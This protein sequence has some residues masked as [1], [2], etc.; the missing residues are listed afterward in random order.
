MR[1]LITGVGGFVGR[2]MWD[3]LQK[4][5]RPPEVF[6]LTR[7]RS[8][9][10]DRRIKFCDMTDTRSLSRVL[11]G[12]DPD[13]IFHLAGGR[14]LNQRE[15]WE[16][17]FG[18]TF[19]LLEVVE[20]L[21]RS[22]RIIVPGSAAELGRVPDSIRQVTERYAPQPLGWYGFVKYR[23]TCLSLMYA[24]RGLDIVVARIFNVLG[25]GTPAAL[26]PGK[27]ARDIVRLEQAAGKNILRTG[28]LGGR[29]DF[30]DIDDVCAALWALARKGKSGEVYHVCS[31]RAVAMREL[32]RRMLKNTATAIRLQEDKKNVSGSFDVIG[33]NRKIRYTTGWRPRV[34]LAESVQATLASYRVQESLG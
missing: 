8:A 25:R 4:Q 28:F 14:S 26:A 23:Q 27:F 33:S 30:V 34:S 24:R 19:N 9:A 13:H 7:Q 11:S 2:A 1:V 3:W 10:R 6:G 18:L 32:V 29:R 22:P 21:R 16:E 31:S 12:V 15:N 17:N 20:K 5:P